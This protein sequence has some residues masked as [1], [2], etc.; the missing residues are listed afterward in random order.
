M[1][2]QRKRGRGGGGAVAGNGTVDEGTAAE[3]TSP[4]YE[5]LRDQRIKENLER[6]QKLGII[7]LSLKLKSASAAAAP[8]RFPKNSSQKEPPNESPADEPP[9]RS[10]RYYFFFPPLFNLLFLCV[11]VCGENGSERVWKCGVIL[12]FGCSMRWVSETM[13]LISV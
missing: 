10:S 1:V 6:M 7:E 13:N 11:C 8:K 3:D 5:K 4:G 9:R 2:S 12:F